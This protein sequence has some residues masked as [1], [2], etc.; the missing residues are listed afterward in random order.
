M[1]EPSNT[2]PKENHAT[3]RDYDHDINPSPDTTRGDLRSDEGTVRTKTPA[4]DVTTPLV[5]QYLSATGPEREAAFEHLRALCLSF[6]APKPGKPRLYIPAPELRT[7]GDDSATFEFVTDWLLEWLE[8]WT[9]KS[10]RTIR[11]AA[12]EGRFRYLGV[13]CQR[14]V[15]EEL[16]HRR[17]KKYKEQHPPLIS[18]DAPIAHDESGEPLTMAAIIGVQGDEYPSGYLSALGKRPGIEREELLA[19]VQSDRDGFD[20]ALGP[21]TAEALEAVVE[22]FPKV[23]RSE[24]AR[25]IAARLHITP[26]MASRYLDDLPAKMNAA[27]R[28]NVLAVRD[29]RTLLLRQ[30]RPVCQLAKATDASLME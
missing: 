7:D 11:R 5:R 26:E 10:E 20:A 2:T 12:K 14:R 27:M 28:N 21:R 4:R 1:E 8:P 29:L 3:V 18:I 24:Q 22:V 30:H 17:T 16:R 6:L 9:K 25:A 19:V 13:A 15:I 23:E